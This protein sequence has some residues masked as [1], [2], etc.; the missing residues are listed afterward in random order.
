MPFRFR[1]SST[2]ADADDRHYD[3]FGP[4]TKRSQNNPPFDQLGADRLFRTVRVDA[5][6]HGE[7]WNEQIDLS[8]ADPWES[9]TTVRTEF[10]QQTLDARSSSR[11]D[12][13]ARS[14]RSLG[15]DGQVSK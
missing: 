4:R 15:D 1:A 14:D 6:A 2:S 10:S 5:G 9:G 8:E 13:A 11:L 7:R 12:I 3:K